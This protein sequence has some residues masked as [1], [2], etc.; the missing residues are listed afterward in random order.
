MARLE[1]QIVEKDS[2][3]DAVLGLQAGHRVGVA[4]RQEALGDAAI[5]L[6]KAV[7]V[8]EA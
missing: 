7:A 5:G 8:A 3:V 4:E 6:A 1:V 2:L